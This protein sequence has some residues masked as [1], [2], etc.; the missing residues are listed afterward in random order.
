M[1]YVL[2]LIM[3]ASLCFNSSPLFA[4]WC[5]DFFGKFRGNNKSNDELP[6][7]SV[8]YIEATTDDFLLPKLDEYYLEYFGKPDFNVNY[9]FKVEQNEKNIES[10]KNFYIANYVLKRISFRLEDAYSRRSSFTFLMNEEM[11]VDEVMAQREKMAEEW[12]LDISPRWED[13]M[14]TVYEIV[15]LVFLQNPDLSS[16]LDKAVK[17]LKPTNIANILQNPKKFIREST[18]VRVTLPTLSEEKSMELDQKIKKLIETI[19][20]DGDLEILKLQISKKTQEKFTKERIIEE[21]KRVL[22]LYLWNIAL[23]VH[24][25]R[26]SE[27]RNSENKNTEESNIFLEELGLDKSGDIFL[28]ELGIDNEFIDKDYDELTLAEKLAKDIDEEL[29]DDKDELKMAKNF[30]MV[31]DNIKDK[32][33][34]SSCVATIV[35]S[36]TVITTASCLAKLNWNGKIFILKDNE[37]VSAV[38]YYIDPGYFKNDF[39]KTDYSEESG[40]GIPLNNIAVVRFPEGTFDGMPQAKISTSKDITEGQLMFPQNLTDKVIKMSRQQTKEDDDE[41]SSTQYGEFKS[42]EPLP[43][44]TLLGYEEPIVFEGEGA[45][46][47]GPNKKVVAVLDEEGVR[48]NG[49][50]SFS[51][52]GDSIKFFEKITAFDKSLIIRGFNRK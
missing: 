25:K 37:M 46:F 20:W 42:V 40:Y 8:I 33:V 10:L 31:L 26:T 32:P 12:G 5:S 39:E 35:S 21:I 17:I 2:C 7:G 3:A 18:E 47:F 11:Y 16:E 27:T 44:S 1:R 22:K 23:E 49:S 41:F 45:P 13:F 24:A 30:K 4:S 28:E 48:P 51:L 15:E 34:H 36:N 29:V 50:G 6:V 14:K 52:L 38:A 19:L 43:K 9:D